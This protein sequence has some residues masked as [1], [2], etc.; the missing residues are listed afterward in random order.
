M[1]SGQRLTGTT[2]AVTA[3]QGVRLTTTSSPPTRPR[4][5][6]E[7]RM[8]PV[9]DCVMEISAEAQETPWAARRLAFAATAD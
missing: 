1:L 7:Y 3:G 4:K 6:F 9:V 5:A 2:A 8:S